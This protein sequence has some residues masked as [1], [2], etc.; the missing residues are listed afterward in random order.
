MY[1]R[2]PQRLPA[3]EPD[4]GLGLASRSSATV[5]SDDDLHVLDLGAGILLDVFINIEGRLTT[6]VSVDGQLLTELRV[7]GQA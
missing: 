5:V 6:F 3:R 4:Q 2:S 7:A 1:R